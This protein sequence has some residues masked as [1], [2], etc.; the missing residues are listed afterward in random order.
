MQL[1]DVFKTQNS[2]IHSLCSFRRNGTRSLGKCQHA[3]VNTV[4]AACAQCELTW[5]ETDEILGDICSSP[6]LLYF[7]CNLFVKIK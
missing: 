7:L 2:S 3:D 1:D 4:K 5:R 6:F